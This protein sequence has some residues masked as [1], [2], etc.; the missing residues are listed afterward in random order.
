MQNKLEQLKKDFLEN[1]K[2]SENL[3]ELEKDFL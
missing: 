1:L 3:E 2:N